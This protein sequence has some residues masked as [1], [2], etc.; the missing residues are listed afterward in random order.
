MRKSGSPQF[1]R[2]H[3]LVQTMIDLAA[4]V[5]DNPLGAVGR[6]W[7]AD[8]KRYA[9]RPPPLAQRCCDDDEERIA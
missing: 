5:F 2:E 3:A 1:A 9:H 6:S 4:L 8:G 7:H